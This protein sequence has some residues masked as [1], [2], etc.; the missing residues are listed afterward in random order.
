MYSLKNKKILVTGALGYIG[1]VFVKKL[2]ELEINYKAIDKRTNG[3]DKV[4]C[5]D[6]TSPLETIK[7]IK[8][9]GPD[10]IFHFGT[11]S[12]LAYRDNLVDSF[13]DDFM[14]VSNI[15]RSGLKKDCRIVYF[16]STY[17]YSGRVGE[18]LASEN[19][20]LK[21]SHN[22]GY[23]KLFFEELILR[24]FNNSVILRLS[25]VF[26]P[27][28]AQHPNAIFN[29]VRECKKSGL[30]TIWGSGARKMQ[31]IYIDDVVD[32]LLGSDCLP[33]GIYNLGGEE[34]VSTRDSASTV[35][36]ILNAKIEYLAE[37]PEGE[38][39]PFM[40]VNKIKE[41]FPKFYFKKFRDSL[42]GYISLINR[43]E[44]E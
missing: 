7:F 32:I 10:Y 31:Y 1:S 12:A 5:L 24:E 34:Y 28:D 33:S 6:L 2:D 25:S 11:H 16:S 30:V 35:A 20:I 39:L 40:T 9:Y 14:S 42:Y 18:G 26:G 43:Y 4:I 22:F 44:N 27:G 41:N 13:Q 17:V 29:M 21:P 37:K 23:A 38:T 36:N 19:E 15:K 8:N 3:H